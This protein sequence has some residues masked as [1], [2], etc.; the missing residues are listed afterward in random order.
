VDVVREAVW[1]ICNCLSGSDMDVCVH[2]VAKLEIMDTFIYVLERITDATI[3][4]VALEGLKSMLSRGV[5]LKEIA[6][7]NFFLEKF[8]EKGGIDQL[9][10]LQYYDNDSVYK[11]TVE[12]MEAFFQIQQES[13][14]N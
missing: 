7:K 9:E 1:L 13:N 10:K 14:I 5:A 4:S 6:G 3:L 11:A 8:K 12:I 2:L